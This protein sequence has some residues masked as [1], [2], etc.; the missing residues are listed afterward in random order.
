MKYAENLKKGATIGVVAPSAGCVVEPYLMRIDNA[1]KAFE[2]MGHKV[3]L[4]ESLF[5]YEKHRSADAKTRAK[6]FME[7]YLSDEIDVLF[8]ATGGEFMTEI[9][10]YIDFEA[11]KNAKPKY[12]IGFSDN[13]TLT[14][15]LAVNSDIA[16]IYGNHFPEY[17]MEEWH[18]TLFDQYDF[19]TGDKLE[20]DSL[21]KYEIK[22]L[23]REEG[24]GLVGYNLTEDSCLCLLTEEK[25]INVTG[26]LV[27][28]CTDILLCILGTEF[29]KTSQFLE[30][31]KEDGFI[32]FLESCDLNVCA[33]TRAMWQMKHAGWFK[34]CK[35]IVIG[36]PRDKEVWYDIDY[37]EANLLH[38]KDLGVP[39][40]MDADFGHT[41]PCNPM[42]C[43]AIANIKFKDNK[44]KI[45]YDLR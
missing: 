13:T 37:K 33:Q 2:K 36:R 16:A 7:F 20:F 29:D 45:T 38:L 32:W 35:A 5:K 28:G 8:S 15:T 34:Y 23:K 43:G 10:P 12:F 27:G 39:V 44:L 21:D 22:S 40:I 30:K 25:E 1:I 24:M 11:L 4:C 19:L 6:E 41:A 18:Q 26:R 17:G 14:Y 9:L 31:Y 42:V 3:V